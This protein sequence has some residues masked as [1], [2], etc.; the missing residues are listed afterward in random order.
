M[1]NIFIA[2]YDIILNYGRIDVKSWW[3]WNPNNYYVVVKEIMKD[4]CVNNWE[5]ILEVI[6]D[7]LKCFRYRENFIKSSVETF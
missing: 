3:W 1:C 4:G 6:I 2:L 5:I 7:N